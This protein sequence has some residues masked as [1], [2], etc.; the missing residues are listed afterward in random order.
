MRKEMMEYIKSDPDLIR[1]LREQ[2]IW[3][4]KLGRNSN[5]LQS[6]QISALHYFKKSIPHR[7][8]KFSNG[9]QMASMMMSL[10]QAM[11]NNQ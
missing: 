2:P 7:V 6:F 9:V 1:F 4:R 10:F 8:E 5:E 11:N 3:Y